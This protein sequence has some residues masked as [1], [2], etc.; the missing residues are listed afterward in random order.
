[1][2]LQRWLSSPVRAFQLGKKVRETNNPDVIKWYSE[3]K[4]CWELRQGNDSVRGPVLT[5]SSPQAHGANV[6]V[7]TIEIYSPEA[8]AQGNKLPSGTQ[9]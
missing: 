7:S 8:K 5:T 2:Y 1:M 4:H 3:E 9:W 6:V